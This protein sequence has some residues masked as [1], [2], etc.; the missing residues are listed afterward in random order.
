M[1]ILA[2]GDWHIGNTFHGRNRAEEHEHFLAWVKEMCV[3]HAPDILLVTGDVFD[4]KEPTP[5][6]Q[7]IYYSFL[8]QLSIKCPWMKTIIIAGNH[9]NPSLLEAPQ[10]LLTELNIEVRGLVSHDLENAQSPII[11]VSTPTGDVFI[12]AVPYLRRSDFSF[13]QETYG[14]AVTEFLSSLV[15]DAREQDGN[16]PVVMAAHLYGAGASIADEDHSE[17]FFVGGEPQ[18]NLTALTDRPDFLFSGHIHKRQN[19]NNCPWA[20]YT[21]SALPMSF[22]ERK[23]KHGAD[24]VTF[25]GKAVKDHVFL[26]YAPLKNL[27]T[28]G[29]AAIDDVLSAIKEDL[30]ILGSDFIEAKVKVDS[31]GT[32]PETKIKRAL[33]DKESLLCDCKELLIGSSEDNADADSGIT[34]LKNASELSTD[35]V[36]MEVLERRFKASVGKDELSDEEKAALVE[37]LTAA[38][39]KETKK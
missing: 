34:S 24:L 10:P 22:T 27:R 1:K 38:R 31:P 5:G 25:K 29:P 4:S 19:I 13:E 11:K 20:Q 30:D 12:I 8:K 14:K 9:D 21:G 15:R 6:S 36:V 35:K 33:G 17:S 3:N 39:E 23:Y 28:Y 18:V 2:T 26:E 32:D 7:K 16:V 37:I